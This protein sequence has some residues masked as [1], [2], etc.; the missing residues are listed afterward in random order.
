ML[1][2]QVSGSGCGG[3]LALESVEGVDLVFFEE[4]LESVDLTLEGLE[5]VVEA[6]VV[7]ESEDGPVELVAVRGAFTEGDELVESTDDLMRDARSNRNVLSDDVVVDGGGT[8]AGSEI[9]DG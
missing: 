9:V 2:E 1:G 7:R 4:V 6:G 8:K 3:G 5:G